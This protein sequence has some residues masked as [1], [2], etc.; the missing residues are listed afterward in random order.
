[1]MKSDKSKT[2]DELIRELKALKAQFKELVK[3]WDRYPVPPQR[4]ED[5]PLKKVVITRDISLFRELPLFRVNQMDG[6]FYLSKACVV[7]RDPENPENQNVGIY[8]IQVKDHDRLGIQASAQHDLAIHI[9]KAEELNQPL[10]VAIAVSNDPVT[11]FVA[12]SPLKYEEDEYGMVGAIRGEPA[13]IIKSEKG[14]LDLPAGAELVIEGEILIKEEKELLHKKTNPEA[15][16]QIIENHAIIDNENVVFTPHIAFYS[17]EALHRIIEN[18]IL[19]IKDFEK[20]D[21]KKEY[22]VC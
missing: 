17:K 5:A 13:K 4:V 3:R 9:R 2:K 21:L 16:K 22:V 12:S 1:M 6:G 11:S 8:R 19:N 15:W 14:N 7:S 20:N 10:R 18:T